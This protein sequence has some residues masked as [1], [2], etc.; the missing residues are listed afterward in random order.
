MFRNLLSL[1]FYCKHFVNSLT[2]VI[3]FTAITFALA[4]LLAS[5][6]RL[7]VSLEALMSGVSAEPDETLA[8]V[9]VMSRGVHVHLSDQGESNEKAFRSGMVRLKRYFPEEIRCVYNGNGRTQSI[10]TYNLYWLA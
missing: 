5:D 9:S 4:I 10:S 7:S 8:N 3:V 6:T 1:Y 2:P